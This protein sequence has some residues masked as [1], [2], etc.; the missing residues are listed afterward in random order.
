MF[1]I[2]WPEILLIAAVAMVLF[3]PG[4][5]EEAAR[6]LGKSVNALKGG[7]KEAFG[8]DDKRPAAKS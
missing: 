6:A 4:R 3:G 7:L 5:V 8:E 1:D 2:G